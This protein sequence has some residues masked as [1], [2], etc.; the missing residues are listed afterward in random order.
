MTRIWIAT[1]ANFFFPGA[2]Y[3]VLGQKVLLG[4]FW[5]VGVIGLTYVEFGIKEAAPSFY[6]P[7]FASVFLM[8]TA[9]AIDAFQTGRAR[10]RG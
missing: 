6:W 5:L 7:M 3:L 1:L 10:L 9:F 2:G 8:N 4:L